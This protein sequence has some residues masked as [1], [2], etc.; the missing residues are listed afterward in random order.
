MNNRIWLDG[1]MGS[2]T[3]DTLGCPVQ[4]RSREEIA[5]NPVTT[6]TG[7]GTYDMPVGT[8]TDDSSMALATLVSIQENK[9]INLADIMYRFA[10]WLTKGEYTPFGEAFDNG[11]CTTEAI[12]RYM[13]EQDVT[14]CGGTDER[15]NGNGSLMRIMPACLYCYEQ[16][17]AGNLSDQEAVAL[18]HQVSGLTHN[19]M[20]SKIACGLYYYMVREILRAGAP[21]TDE[22]LA[23]VL[24]R[25]LDEGFAFY[26]QD[27]KHLTE[28]SYYGRLH[29]LNAFRALP[30]SEI[31]SSGY[32]VD[33]LEAAVWSLLKTD[34]FKDALLTA[35]NLGQD[36][37]TVGAVC[38]G[39]AGLFYGY[40]DIPGEWLTVIQRREWIETL[41]RGSEKEKAGAGMNRYERRAKNVEIFKDTS[42]QCRDIPRL[43]DSIIASTKGRKLYLEKDVLPEKTGAGKQYENPARIIVSGKRSYEAAQYYAGK[44]ICVLNFASSVNP[45]GGVKN[46]SSAQEES[47][48]RCSTLYFTLDSPRMMTKFYLPHREAKNTLYNDDIIYTPAV[49]VFKGDTDFPEMLPEEDWYEVDV[50][51]CA[52]PNLR[53]QD[54]YD[55]YSDHSD[56][57]GS[58]STE[59]LKKLIE[60]RVRRIYEVAAYEENEVFIAGAFGCGAFRN[61][62]ELVAEVFRK[63]T[64]E[65]RH[66]FETI[67]FAVFCSSYETE[68]YKAFCKAFG[69]ML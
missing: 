9:G 1:I 65:Y 13:T 16:Q 24:Q 20:R 61:P 67:E 28:L 8:W 27:L 12:L 56:G 36:T 21:S 50:L 57:S 29:D 44:K 40:E 52:A 26:K 54:Q 15:D 5:R 68:N 23:D 39:L 18:V 14:T 62:P 69:D 47:L 58:L 22:A 60:K 19:H 63:V 10:L 42:R 37:D 34:T 51:T 45:G 33:T 66:F 49:T 25:G 35:V 31:R 48:C 46:G 64:E 53:D 7:H 17:D 59:E 43:S 32:V 30:A 6:M 3:G 4:F 41:C 11:G 2:V 38:G 55:P